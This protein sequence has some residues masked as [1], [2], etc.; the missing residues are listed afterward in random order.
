M[1]GMPVATTFTLATPAQRVTAFSVG[2]GLVL[3]VP[4]LV[5]HFVH[6]SQL[7]LAQAADSVTDAVTAA[8]F[9]YSLRVS[10]RPADAD[11]PRGHHRAEPIAALLAA[12][13]AGVLA[14]EVFREALGVL[15][16]GAQPV[17]AWSLVAVFGV[18]I[19]AKT[20]L[21]LTARRHQRGVRS[22]ALHVL[23]VDARNDVLVGLVAVVGFFCARFGSPGWDAWL[24][25]PIACWIAWSGVGLASQNI[26]LLMGEAPPVERQEEL[27]RIVREVRGVESVH[28][29]NARYDGT[30]IDVSLH[31]VVDEQLSLR[32][33]HDIAEA[34][35][36]RLMAEPDV[37][38]AMVHVDVEADPTR[39]PAGTAPT[40]A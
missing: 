12:V 17:M 38:L 35:E 4:L 15:R 10:G 8:A 22:P 13:L 6:D 40:K 29:L 21:S 7:A 34:V 39:L 28:D 16:G 37:L 14:V 5:A 23:E 36:A 24:A 32:K 9:L 2:L 18:K 3:A 27:L 11:H 1:A 26:R 31:I 25:L 30:Q 20:A 19:A 33:A